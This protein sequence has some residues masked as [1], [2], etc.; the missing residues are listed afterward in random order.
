MNT[1]IYPSVYNTYVQTA[2]SQINNY[3]P[4]CERMSQLDKLPVEYDTQERMAYICQSGH[5]VNY[6]RDGSKYF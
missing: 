1:F 5:V 3:C 2:K 6:L 4:E